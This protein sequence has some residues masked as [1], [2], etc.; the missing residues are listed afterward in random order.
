MLGP[1]HMVDRGK[2]R[3]GRWVLRSG[4]YCERP[5]AASCRDCIATFDASEMRQWEWGTIVVD[6]LGRMDYEDPVEPYGEE[7]ARWLATLTPE[8]RSW[9]FLTMSN[10]AMIELP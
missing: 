6:E 2:T 4:V 10:A 1:I 9:A 3:C 8:A 7:A 5:G